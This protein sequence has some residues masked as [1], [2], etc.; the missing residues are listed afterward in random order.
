M[1]RDPRFLH[2]FN[3]SQYFLPME[4]WLMIEAEIRKSTDKQIMKMEQLIDVNYIENYEGAYT[5]RI[6]INTS[7]RNII[8][9]VL[10]WQPLFEP[11]CDRSRAQLTIYKDYGHLYTS[12]REIALREVINELFRNLSEN[13]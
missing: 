7:R 2:V 10:R 13:E 11:L 9:R 3:N 6:F 8:S 4:I 12:P 1:R 5:E